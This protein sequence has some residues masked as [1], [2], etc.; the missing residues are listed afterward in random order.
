M[1]KGKVGEIRFLLVQGHQ[2]GGPVAKRVFFLF[3][4]RCGA[5]HLGVVHFTTRIY[6]Y[7]LN[8]D[9]IPP[10]MG[11]DIHGIDK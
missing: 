8:A 1:L 7:N 4:K 5:P 9:Q 6:S 11:V 3:S 2:R 10:T